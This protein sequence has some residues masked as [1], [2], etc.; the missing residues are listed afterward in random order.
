MV[1]IELIQVC[2]TLLRLQKQ[3]EHRLSQSSIVSSKKMQFIKL[4]TDL[5]YLDKTNLK[6]FLVHLCISYCLGIGT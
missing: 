1:K 5:T 2:V 4:F 6:F 3:E